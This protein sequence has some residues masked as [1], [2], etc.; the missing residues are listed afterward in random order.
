ML[1][2]DIHGLHRH[3]DLSKISRGQPR[4]MMFDDVIFMASFNDL[5]SFFGLLC[6]QG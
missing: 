5:M 4:S 6:S 2:D 3:C 1:R